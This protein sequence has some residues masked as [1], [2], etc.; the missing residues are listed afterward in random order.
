[1]YQY[2]FANN[3][4]RLCEEQNLS[5]DELAERIGKSSRQV[6]RY[7]NGNCQNITLTTVEKI[8]NVLQVRMSELLE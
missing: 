1:M 5:I 7:R 4:C 2:L 8:A 3:L 6:S